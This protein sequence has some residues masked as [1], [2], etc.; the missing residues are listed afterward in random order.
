[1][2]KII[3][4]LLLAVILSGC[5]VRKVSD[6]DLLV[7]G[8]AGI[9]AVRNN[10]NSKYFS[11]YLP[12]DVNETGYSDTGV[13]LDYDGDRIVMNLNVMDLISSS[14]EL[15]DDGFFSKDH[16]IYEKAGEFDDGNGFVVDIYG[17]DSS[18][19]IYVR[20][21]KTCFYAYCPEDRV[22]DLTDRIML[23]ARNVS[24]NKESVDN[25][26]SNRDVID[27]QRKQIDLF[28]MVIAP[29]GRLEDLLISKPQNEEPE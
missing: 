6:I 4:F 23:L 11:Y 5:S 27:F 17:H 9:P 28:E 12:S 21:L 29:D 18:A 8:A 15:H 24:V 2:R 3:A 19:I 10:K 22:Y 16:L 20:T 26:F 13:V 1:M 7:S 14:D 25:D